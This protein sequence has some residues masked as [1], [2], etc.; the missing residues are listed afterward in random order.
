MPNN[1]KNTHLRK[2]FPGKISDV[3]LMHM[4]VALRV[5]KYYIVLM[6]THLKI[7]SF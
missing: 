4:L 6:E 5:K 7:S 1:E 3:L 2:F